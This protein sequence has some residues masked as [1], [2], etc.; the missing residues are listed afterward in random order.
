M[1]KT[2]VKK[3]LPIASLMMMIG[4][5]QAQINL[6]GI[7]PSAGQAGITTIYITC[8]GFP[9]GTPSS[10]PAVQITLTPVGGGSP[11]VIAPTRVITM[12]GQFRRLVFTLPD[13]PP[14]SQIFYNVSVSDPTDGLSGGNNLPF[15]EDPAPSISLLSPNNG[16]QGATNEMV[17]ITGSFTNF[18]QGSTQAN[19]GAGITVNSLTVNS[20]T[21]ATA[22][23]NIAANAATG[24]RSITVSSGVQSE[25]AN[26]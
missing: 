16:S 19:F 11:V 1:P 14:L 9:T 20:P 3:L 17:G 23:I 25:T 12:G 8:N 10:L 13:P 4:I 7:S 18:L 26:F 24:G 5:A 6:S 2:L 15:T 21:S 22:S